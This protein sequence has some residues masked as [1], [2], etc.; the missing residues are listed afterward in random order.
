MLDYYTPQGKIC[1]ALQG[2][3]IVIFFRF[4]SARVGN[5]FIVA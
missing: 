3:K 1:Q 2:K 4:I 5:D